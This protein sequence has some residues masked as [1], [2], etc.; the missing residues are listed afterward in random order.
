MALITGNS[1]N[2]LLVGSNADDDIRGNAGNDT[3]NGGGGND[4]LRGGADNDVYITDGG[5]TLIEQPNQGIDE[6][7]ASVGFVLGPNFENLTL[8]GTA[9]INGTGNS[10]ANVLAGNA[11]N[12]VLDGGAGIDTFQMTREAGS[13]W[14][15]EANLTTGVATG[16]GTDTLLN[17]E[18]VRGTESTDYITG[19][20]GNNLIDG[21][22]GHDEIF[23]SEG[24]DTLIGG[25][26]N[27]GIRFDSRS[28]ATLNLAAGNYSL[29][30]G[31]AG[32]V[33]SINHAV[34]SA[35]N[36]SLTGNSDSNHLSGGA[37]AD[38]LTG[39]AGND[40]LWGGPGS[41]RLVA[42]LGS[43]TLVG[44]SDYISGAQ[45]AAADIFEVRPGADNVTIT[46]FQPGVDK[47]DLTSFGFDAN[48][49]SSQWNASASADGFHTVL[50]LVN[51]TTGKQVC[52]SLQG[53]AQGGGNPLALGDF[54]GGSPGLIPPPP[55]PVNGGNG[56]AD[57]FVI[58]PVHIINNLGGVLDIIGFEDGLDRVDLT[59][60]N[61]LTG[62]NWDGWYYDYGPNDQ[63]RLEFWDLTGQ[64]FAVNLVGHSYFA[65]DPSDFIL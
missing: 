18:N 26:G 57:I 46:D 55:G 7:R 56:V 13:N 32:L 49:H 59:A 28:A 1:A 54:I 24:F 27:D 63:T 60:L 41:D 14:L 64:F 62:G 8:T 23:V 38:T 43:D 17:F 40:Q 48:G 11:G 15:T 4:T 53:L 2:N 39:G 61:L 29:A 5:D 36:D 42:D 37:G 44:N 51:T 33:S 35:F 19:N 45:D 21:A 30:S 58:D 47:I 65:A 22:G 50:R 10:A 9:N 34:G 3:L 25:A 20:A 6:V 16:H 52:I 12:N 31:S